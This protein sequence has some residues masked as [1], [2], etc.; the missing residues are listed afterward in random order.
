MS[1]VA[2]IAFVAAFTSCSKSTDV[3]EEGR[4]EKDQKEQEAK[5]TEQTFKEAFVET[6]GTPDPTHNW[7]FDTPASS[8]TATRA[9]TPTH[10]SSESSWNGWASA[11]ETTDY[12]LEIPDGAYSVS[13][14]HAHN[15]SLN[16]YYLLDQEETQEINCWVGNCNMYVSGKKSVNFK[17]PGDGNDNF[18][19][20]ILPNADLTFTTDY[21]YNAPHH[22]MYV[23]EKA[24]VTFNGKMSANIKIYNRGTITIKGEAGP[25]ANGVIYN[26]GGR[27]ICENSLNVF[28]DGAQIINNGRITVTGDITVQGSGHFQNGNDGIIIASGETLVNS[29]DCSWI[30]NGDYT[31]EKFTYQAGSTDVINNCMLTVNEEFYINLGDT[32]KNCFLM[33]GGAGVVA[34]SFHLAGPGFIYMGS[35]SVFKVLGDAIMDATKDNYG[36]Y[37]PTTGAPAV[38][39]AVGNITTSNIKQGYDITY[40]NNIAVVATDHFDSNTDYSSKSGDYPVV[41]F[42]NCTKDIIYTNGKKPSI[43]ITAGK[44]NPGFE[45]GEEEYDGRIMAEDLNATES[46]DFDY[47]DVVFD[48]KIEGNKAKIKLRAAG[49]IYHLTVGDVE[50]HEK[51]GFTADANGNY[52]MINTGAGHD[53]AIA[54]EYDYTFPTGTT[55]SAAN[56]PVIVTKKDIPYT[57]A[58][59]TGDAAAK[60]CVVTTCKW[61]KER[62]FI[63]NAYPKFDDWVKDKSVKWTTDIKD[64]SLLYNE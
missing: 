39:Y 42:S 54:D 15:S 51:F 16:N 31:T 3:Y 8:R 17:A 45:G 32:D 49:G 64:P 11:P 18:N 5:K 14:Y 9:F 26:D 56:I 53:G 48:Y 43:T 12:K 59:P 22:T 24:N 62:K 52:P 61:M 36:I 55:A 29:N 28:N 37:G 13:E 30:N 7:G 38:F 47:N 35:G 6:F 19:Y 10:L 34:G 25:Y 63:S 21:A 1:G 40:G 44:C 2:A 60:F 23:A 4:K 46:S 20:Y 33:N 41:N 27:I 57:L 58:A 50:V